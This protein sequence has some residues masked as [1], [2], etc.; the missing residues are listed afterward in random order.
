MCSRPA[1]SRITTCARGFGLLDGV[2][3]NGDRIVRPL[4]GVDRDADLLA[5][6]LQLMHGRR[7]LQVRGHEHRLAAALEQHAGQLAAG[8]GFARALQAAH[9]QDR[10]IRL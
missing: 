7:A 4:F 10:E 9:H 5:Q 8:R 2:L 3:A 1:V 6:H